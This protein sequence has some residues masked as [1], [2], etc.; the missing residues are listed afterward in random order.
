MVRLF[1]C[2]RYVHSEGVKLRKITFG[3]VAIILMLALAVPAMTA[4]PSWAAGG[5]NIVISWTN[6]SLNISTGPNYSANGDDAVLSI[7]DLLANLAT[8]NVSI[9]TGSVGIQAGNINL[10]TDLT[11]VGPNTLSLIAANDIDINAAITGPNLD[12][13]LDAGGTI[14]INS[15]IDVRSLLLQGTEINIAANAITTSESQIYGNPVV[16]GADTSLTTSFGG[17]ISFASSVDGSGGLTIDASGNVIFDDRIGGTNPLGNLDIE[18]TVDIHIGTDTI[19]TVGSQEYKSD[20]VLGGIGPT[21][22]ES[23]SSFVKFLGNFTGL[24]QTTGKDVELKGSAT[25]QLHSAENINQ[26]KLTGT[27]NKILTGNISNVIS[28]DIAPGGV[29]TINASQIVTSESQTYG[30]PLILGTYTSLTTTTVGGDISFAYSVDGFGGLTIDASGNVIF[31]YTIGH[32]VPLS[33]FEVASSGVVNLPSIIRTT[34]DQLYNNPIYLVTNTN[35]STTSTGNIIFVDTVDGGF[36]LAI[37]AKGNVTFGDTVGASQALDSLIITH[38]DS[39]IFMDAFTAGT[40]TL[41]GIT[42]FQTIA[43]RGDTTITTGLTTANEGYNVSFTGGSN[44]VAGDTTFLNTETVTLGDASTDS[45]TFI[46][47]LGTTGNPSNPSSTNLAGTIR[48]TDTQIDLG[49]VTLTA[50][51]TL[52][53]GTG[54]GDL[55]LNGIVTGGSNNLQLISGS[56]ATTA[57]GHLYN[58]DVLTLQE[59]VATST[60]AMVFNDNSTVNTL[61]TF[62]QNYAVSLLG[63]STIVTTDTTFSNTGGITIGDNSSGDTFTGNVIIPNGVKLRGDCIIVGNVTINN[64]GIIA[65]GSSDT[66]PGIFNLQGNL[67]LNAGATYEADFNGPNAGQYD[68]IDVIGSIIL[69]TSGPRA[70]LEL[71]GGFQSV[72]PGGETIILINNDGTDAVT[73]LFEAITGQLLTENFTV[74]VGDFTG[75]ISYLGGG[76]TGNDVVLTHNEAPT[77]ISLDNNSVDEN[78]SGAIIANVTVTDPDV[79]DSHICTVDDARFEVVG[80]QLKLK[81]GESL[82]YEAEPSVNIEVTAEDAGTLQYTEVFVI[83]VNDVNEAPPAAGATATDVNKFSP[84]TAYSF[85]VTYTDD[86]AIDVSTIIGNNAGVRGTGP[87]GFNQ[88]ATY[89][90]VDIPVDGTPRTATYQI[91]P[92]G[93]FWDAVDNGVYTISMEANQ[94]FDSGMLPIPAGNLTTFN[95]I[96]VNSAPVATGDD[97]LTNEDTAFTTGDVLAN[98]TDSDTDPLLVSGLDMTGTIGSVTNNGDGTFDYDP[99][100]QFEYLAIGE[101]A[102]DT[103]TY[104]MT[105]GNGEFDTATVT[106][107]ITGV[108]DLPTVTTQAVSDIGITT[109][110]GN[111][112]ITIL[113]AP[114]PTAHGVVWNTSGTPTTADSSTD[115]GVA[116]A[117]GS[118]TTSITGLSPDTTYYVRAYATNIGGTVYGDAMT[119]VTDPATVPTVTTTAISN[120]GTNSASGGGNVTA[121]NGAAVTA[122]GVCWNTSH[123]PTIGHSATTNA[124]GTGSFASSIAGLS[125]GTTYYVRAYAT[126]AAGT[127]YGDEVAFVT[128][129]QSYIGGGYVPPV[130]TPVPTSTPTPALSPTPTPIPSATPDPTPT[131]PVIPPLQRDLPVGDEGVTTEAV[132]VIR[133]CR[134][135]KGTVSIPEGT[136]C[137]DAGGNPLS[138]ITIESPGATGPVPPGMHMIGVCGFGPDG[139][140]FDPPLMI[141]TSYNPDDFSDGT[142]ADDLILV[143]Y[144]E[145]SGIWIELDDIVVDTENHTISGRI[146]HFTLIGVMA[147]VEAA[148]EDQQPVPTNEATPDPDPAAP[149]SPEGES[150]LTSELA[151]AEDDEDN[152]TN[153]LM[154]IIPIIAVL[155]LGLGGYFVI[156]RGSKTI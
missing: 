74:N 2:C 155:I 22:F 24:G 58:I 90:S 21:T 71:V 82:N 131:P 99:N 104:T 65:P 135:C 40:V 18:S 134:N 110:T 12:L 52:D 114:D 13:I 48:T 101:T 98:D 11:Y 9:N 37:D 152:G 80:G 44:S 45:I 50:N 111:G 132:T 122:R 78:G 146:S 123:N 141:T 39:T 7:T 121:D 93:S 32:T 51:T 86:A 29:T 112:T 25:V 64:G 67:T 129:S 63:S 144:D 49:A 26:L 140:T 120:I 97:Y 53:T 10:Q 47:G 143:W 79:G 94:V 5:Y 19:V 147:K 38:S 85:T 56:G 75:N 15:D 46:G 30:T 105:D 43:F 138:H 57:N 73:G 96:Y 4:T 20:V 156:V 115:E 92:P 139:A 106:I 89:V 102:T 35:L 23:I 27:G 108:N 127:G 36:N 55:N 130:S 41:T 14:N 148:P 126:N 61:T 119:L 151:M 137:L 116:S 8:A 34:G 17:D 54:A 91:T 3:M 84:P 145:S 62:A 153:P 28:L 68:Q 142:S 136:E 154:V 88:L 133:E 6:F 77:D 103:F 66:T 81:A 69:P 76:G 59:N 150:E 100:G 70:I 107:T 16:L 83:T 60:G 124:T 1:S 33:Y 72:P 87:G 113:G 117:I 125:A 109:A 149:A 128:A 31:G 95:V 118:F 42:D